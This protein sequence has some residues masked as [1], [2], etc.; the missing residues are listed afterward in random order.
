LTLLSERL[1]RADQLAASEPARARAIRKAVVE[2]YQEKP[3]AAAAVNRARQALSAEKSP[4][5]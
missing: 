4:A 5:P 3:W 1:D 2:L